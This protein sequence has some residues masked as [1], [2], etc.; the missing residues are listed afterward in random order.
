MMG[1]SPCA[2]TFGTAP[3]GLSKT[4]STAGTIGLDEAWRTPS[5]GASGALR[6]QYLLGR[7]G[8]NGGEHSSAGC[9]GVVERGGGGD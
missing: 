5:D 7:G 3:G 4:A 6:C 8:G 1:A 9:V 2:E